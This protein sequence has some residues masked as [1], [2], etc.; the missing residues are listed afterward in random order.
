MLGI[1]SSR[2]LQNPRNSQLDRHSLI[3]NVVHVRRYEALTRGPRPSQV[4]RDVRPHAACCELI[5]ID[6]DGSFF[7]GN[8]GQNPNET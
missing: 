3:A 7:S 6:Q 8:E 5:M 1:R 4:G 2:A